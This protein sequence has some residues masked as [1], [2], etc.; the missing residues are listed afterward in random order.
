MMLFNRIRY[1]NKYIF[2]RLM[3]RFAGS[4]RSRFAVVRHVGRRSGRSYETPIIVAPLGTDVVVALTYGPHV[5]WYRNLLATGHGTLRRQGRTYAIRA[6]EPISRTAALRQFP[7]LQR[8]I[9]RLLGIEHFVRM[10]LGAPEAP[11]T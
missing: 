9:L 3:L 6:L 5:D 11:G 1:F 7:A 10:T 8:G 2:N 4:S